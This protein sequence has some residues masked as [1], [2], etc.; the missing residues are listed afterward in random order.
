MNIDKTL[1]NIYYNPKCFIE[2]KY[3]D[4]YWQ[5]KRFLLKEDTDIIYYTNQARKQG[6]LMIYRKQTK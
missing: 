2:N 3:I 4:M 6:Y 1:K 5:E